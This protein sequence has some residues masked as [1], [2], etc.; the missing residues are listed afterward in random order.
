MNMGQIYI[1]QFK[2]EKGED[3]L[4][5]ASQIKTN[6]KLFF[7]RAICYLKQKKTE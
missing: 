5:K 1:N 7:R 2:Y 3:V 4:N 6:A